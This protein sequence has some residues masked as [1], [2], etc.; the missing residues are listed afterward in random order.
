MSGRG[1]GGG[2]GGRGGFRG[3]RPTN[4]TR[5]VF[6]DAV[7]FSIDKDID[8]TFDGKPS[9]LFP[10]YDIPKPPTLTKKEEKQLKSFLL[11]RAQCHDSPLYT[12]ARAWDKVTAGAGK[13]TYGQEQINKR[14]KD[15]SLVDPFTSVPTHSS[16]FQVVPRTVPDLSSHPFAKENFPPELHSTLDGNAN[17]RRKV[18]KSLGLSN[19]TSYKTV[20]D[21]EA[22]QLALAAGL[23]G[24][25]GSYDKALELLKNAENTAEE[26]GGLLLAEDDDDWVKN[27]GDN[28]DGEGEQEVEED[29]YDDESGDDYNA[30]QYF[31][32]GGDRDDYEDDAGGDDAFF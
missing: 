30:E 32:D 20:E 18:V 22:E 2:R 15:D 14:Y 25:D 27:N 1:R 5:T 8:T 4:G 17:K 21:L 31:E 19:I 12:Q 6:K 24:A 10:D 13:R 28:E 26:G 9:E 16:R 7:P 23:P 29:D 3:G 11:L